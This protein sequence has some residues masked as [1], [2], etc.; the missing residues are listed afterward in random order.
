MDAVL[1]QAGWA[2][3]HRASP[4]LDEFVGSGDRDL[5]QILQVL[6]LAAPLATGAL[7]DRV[8]PRGD[9]RLLEVLSLGLAALLGVHFLTSL[10]RARLLVELRARLDERM[11]LGFCQHLCSLPYRFFQLRAAGDLLLRL[12]SNGTVPA[13]DLLDLTLVSRN[14]V[15]GLDLRVGWR[16]LLKQREQ[17]V[18]EYYYTPPT[19]RRSRF[20]WVELTG[21]FR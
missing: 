15:A 19:D 5:T 13:R 17:A 14:A 18:D 3:G 20:A 4:D 2:F 10:L 6:A 7:V 21:T 12:N 1:R 11:T 8:V 16:N 9:L